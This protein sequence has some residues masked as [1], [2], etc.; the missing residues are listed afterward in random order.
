MRKGGDDVSMLAEGVPGRMS[1]GSPMSSDG[2]SPRT[3][4]ITDL[5][6]LKT[7]ECDGITGYRVVPALVALPESTAEVA[8]WSRPAPAPDALRAR[9][10]GT[11]L[12]AARSRWRRPS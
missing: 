9:G 12:S 11:G 6:R 2:S 10:A 3:R 7:Y 5:T 1:V 8:Q 4:V